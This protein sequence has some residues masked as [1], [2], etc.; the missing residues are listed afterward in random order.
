MKTSKAYTSGCIIRVISL[1]KY[2]R[3]SDPYEIAR[4][5]SAEKQKQKH[6]IIKK[7]L[8]NVRIFENG[9]TIRMNS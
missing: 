6:F 9:H 3:N 5:G 1:Y 2:P 7:W 4:A 8:L